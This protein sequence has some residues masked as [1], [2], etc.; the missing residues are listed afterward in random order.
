MSGTR[1][2]QGDQSLAV[3]R[4]RDKHSPIV[5]DAGQCV[6][7][8]DKGR[9]RRR[10]GCRRDLGSWIAESL[11]SDNVLRLVDGLQ[12]E[13]ARADMARSIGCITIKAQPQEAA[14]EL[15]GL[16]KAPEGS[17]HGRSGRRRDG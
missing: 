9:S 3:D 13:E 1:V 16:R 6:K 12:V 10:C 17:R 5:A 2:Q 15:L 8:D 4:D 11:L 14:L 7:G